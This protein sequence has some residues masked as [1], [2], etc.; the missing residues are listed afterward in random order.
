MEEDTM[1]LFSRL[2]RYTLLLLM[3]VLGFTTVIVSQWT[4]SSFEDRLIVQAENSVGSLAR[5]LS[6]LDL[7]DGV[8]LDQERAS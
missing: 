6:L 2:M 1:S 4:V 3:A 7:S 5:A 8:D